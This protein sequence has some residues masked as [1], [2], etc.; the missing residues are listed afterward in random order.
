MAARK[1]IK[2]YNNGGS[3]LPAYRVDGISYH[4]DQDDGAEDM[5]SL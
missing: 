3:G 1:E 4:G 2:T 5:G